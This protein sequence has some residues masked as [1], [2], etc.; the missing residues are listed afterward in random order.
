MKDG[1]FS[2][3]WERCDG[4]KGHVS[5][6]CHI[7]LMVQYGRRPPTRGLGSATGRIEMV[8]HFREKG[9]P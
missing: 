4:L 1:S 5:R 3:S 7:E 9:V 8:S 6:Y 2:R